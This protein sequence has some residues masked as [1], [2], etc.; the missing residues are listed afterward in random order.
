VDDLKVGKVQVVCNYGVFTEGFDEPKLYACILARPT[1]NLGLYLQM[2]GRSLRPAADKEDS[3]IIDHS[4]NVYEH[5]FVQ[6]QHDW[7]LQ[8][9]RALCTEPAERQREFDE[10]KPITCVKCA[11]VYV[12]QLPCP[13][14]G[15]V[16]EKKGRYVASR[17]GDL[18]EVRHEQRR[19]AQ[20]RKFT[21][22]GREQWYQS[23]LAIARDKEYKKP[24]GWSAHQYKKKF[25]EWP[26]GWFEQTPLAEPVP[27]VTSWVRGMNL[28][29]HYAKRKHDR[30]KEILRNAR[31]VTSNVESGG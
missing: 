28:R 8:E 2:A 24:L 14:C 19:T 3:L 7:I 31:K 18:M 23:L 6:D 11:T 4:G 21:P 16:P 9:G 20:S 29:Y 30:G 22:E 17:S 10:K 26:E 15:H 13:N 12:R 27:E 1:K 5:G 25:K